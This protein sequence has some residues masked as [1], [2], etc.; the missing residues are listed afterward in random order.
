M[1]AP[2][3]VSRVVEERRQADP[4]YLTGRHLAMG[5]LLTEGDHLYMDRG[6]DWRGALK[7]VLEAVEC[8]RA[9][10]G[11]NA[12]V[13]RD[14]PTAD[15]ELGQFLREQGFARRPMPESLVLPVDWASDEAY[16]ARLSRRA[17][18][19]LRQDVLPHEPALH[20]EVLEQGGRM[21]SEAELAH[22]HAL[23]ENVR[24]RNLALNTF[25]LPEGIFRHMLESPCWELVTVRLAPDAPPVGVAAY[26]KGPGTYVPMVLGLS[27]DAVQSHGLYRQFLLQAARRGKAH[28]A[29]VIY[30]GMGATLEKQRLGAQVVSRSV[31]VQANDHYHEDLMAQVAQ[32]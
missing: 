28:G 20:V 23:T 6:A 11:A 15:A 12:L 4:Y 22:F 31:Y 5:S 2:E 1:L 26:F 13:L 25:A 10:C 16:M 30:M 9:A 14:L 19:M 24:R 21:P 32:A 29:E 18:R 7:L 8:E 27:Y 17:R 3:A